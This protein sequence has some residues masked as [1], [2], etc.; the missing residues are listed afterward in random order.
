MFPIDPSY[1]SLLASRPLRLLLLGFRFIIN[2]D[3]GVEG[4]GERTRVEAASDELK[5]CMGDGDL[6]RDA[7]LDDGV[8]TGGSGANDE[9]ED[10]SED[11]EG[12]LTRPNFA[13]GEAARDDGANGAEA[14]FKPSSLAM[15]AEL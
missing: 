10:D 13:E 9:D 12:D 6:S 15:L 3:C 8:S 11:G 2:R 14:E 5:A 4:A 7:E 1:S